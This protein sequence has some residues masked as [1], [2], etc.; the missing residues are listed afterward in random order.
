VGQVIA[1]PNSCHVE[2]GSQPEVD[3]STYITA[4]VSVF[5]DLQKNTSIEERYTRDLSKLTI[6]RTDAQISG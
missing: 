6:D 5:A 2:F 3:C 1:F 4:G